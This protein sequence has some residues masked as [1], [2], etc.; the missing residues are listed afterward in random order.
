[1]TEPEL[2]MNQCQ[3]YSCTGNFKAYI[4]AKLKCPFYGTLFIKLI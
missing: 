1:M 4:Q 2:E 3:V